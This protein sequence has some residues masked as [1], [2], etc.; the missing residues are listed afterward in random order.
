MQLEFWFDFAS[1][2]SYPAAM[3]I[4]RLA[5][6]EGLELA[7][8]PFLLGPVFAQQGMK[9][10]PF[11]LFP[12]RGRYMWR[13]LERICAQ[14]QLPWKMPS[15]FPANSVEAAKVALVALESPWGPEFVRA[16]Y[17]ANF[18]EDRDIASRDVLGAVLRE[19][20]QDPAE[21]FA[22]VDGPEQKGKLRV[23][24]EEAMRRGIFGAP[25]FFIGDE[26]FFGQDRMVD[27]VEWAARRRA[28]SEPR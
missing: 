8:K 5:T 23:Q 13:D 6:D 9:D 22:R 10:S 11:N 16:V 12:T 26:M 20:G 28:T 24:T 2:Y 1:T 15:R 21:V 14:H 4:E 19:L 18:G 17:R 27:A 25:T 7:W 3:R